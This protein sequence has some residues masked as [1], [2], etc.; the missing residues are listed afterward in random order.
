MEGSCL[1]LQLWLK[2]NACR[3]DQL[4]RR[5]HNKSRRDIGIGIECVIHLRRVPFPFGKG[6]LQQHPKPF[7]VVVTSDTQS[8]SFRQWRHG[9]QVVQMRATHYQAFQTNRKVVRHDVL[10]GEWEQPIQFQKV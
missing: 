1:R 3:G 6:S 4:T 8:V 5:F 2:K 7:P 10:P 9:G